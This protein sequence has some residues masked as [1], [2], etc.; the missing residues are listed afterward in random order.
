[1][2]NRFQSFKNSSLFKSAIILSIGSGIGQLISVLVSPLLTRIYTPEEFGMFTLFVSI[3]STASVAGAG[4]LELAQLVPKRSLAANIVRTTAKV[5]AI[6]FSLL[7]GIVLLLLQPKV[8]ENTLYYL[9]LPMTILLISFGSIQN[10]YATRKNKFKSISL[11]NLI[12]SI[13]NNS[14]AIALGLFQ[15]SLGL[16][17]GYIVGNI[18]FNA[19]IRFYLPKS[20]IYVQTV[21]EHLATLTSYKDFPTTNS[22]SAFSNM[23]TNQLPIIIMAMVFDNTLIGLYGLLM[24]VLNMPL[25]FFG[26]SIS[27]VLFSRFSSE[28]RKG[29]SMTN[30]VQ[31]LAI[32]LFVGITIVMLPFVFWGQEIF[33][34]A[35]GDEWSEAGRLVV[36]FIP[37]YILRFVYFCLSTLMIVK[38]RLKTDLI[39][40]VSA[41]FLQCVMLYAGCYIFENSDITFGLIGTGGALS[42]L[43]FLFQLNS[44]NSKSVK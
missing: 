6:I 17:V 29:A 23:A 3:A 20:R 10:Y 21:K 25:I 43:I 31:N 37:F 38:R 34:I 12:K 1:L 19:F 4:R 39:Q 27:Q 16:I 18:A 30:W 28:E 24:K 5:F 9:L 26:R 15:Y 22:L 7:F 44:I 14:I 11:G 36:Y 40:N 41:L 8:I 13:S 42:Y 2:L 32:Y 35:F 33:S